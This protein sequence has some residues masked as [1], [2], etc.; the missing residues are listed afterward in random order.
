MTSEQG[1]WTPILWGIS[2]KLLAIFCGSAWDT[3]IPFYPLYFPVANALQPEIIAKKNYTRD[4]GFPLENTKSPP[5]RKSPKITQKLQFGPPR[6]RPENYRKN[7]KKC[8][9]LAI[10]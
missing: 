9:F 5:P 4:P 8:I 7:T 10:Y 1:I 2:P 6:A 3:L